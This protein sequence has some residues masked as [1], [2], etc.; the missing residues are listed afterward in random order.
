MTATD[1]ASHAADPEETSDDQLVAALKAGDSSAADQLVDRHTPALLGY[2]RR[3]ARGDASLA[4]DLHQA[5]WLSVLEHLDQF[6]ESAAGPGFKPWLFRIATNK[7]HDHFRRTGRERRR[8]DRVA[9]DPT[10]TP[11]DAEAADAD[12]LRAEQAEAIRHLVLELPDPQRRVVEL[13]C[14]AGLTFKEIADTLDCPLN[15]AL[16]RMHKAVKKLRLAMES[17]Q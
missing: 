7:A 5:T 11:D 16:G 2:L 13:R 17:P 15:T 3:I 14:F 12:V 1:D 4:E 9:N 10:L 6:D 8:V